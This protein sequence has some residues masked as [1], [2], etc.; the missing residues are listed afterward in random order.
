MLLI[1]RPVVGR[2]V[3]EQID[4]VLN[5]SFVSPSHN[6]TKPAF[7]LTEGDRGTKNRSAAKHGPARHDK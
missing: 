2:V 4:G 3:A 7:S 1:N 5:Y 6:S